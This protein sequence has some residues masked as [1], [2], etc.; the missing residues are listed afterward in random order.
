MLLSVDCLHPRDIS[1]PLPFPQKQVQPR[2]AYYMKHTAELPTSQYLCPINRGIVMVKDHIG[3]ISYWT[4][5]Y[6]YPQNWAL[7]DDNFT[8]RKY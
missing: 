6:P 8:I 4:L 1:F 7:L 2:L 5:G 3:G